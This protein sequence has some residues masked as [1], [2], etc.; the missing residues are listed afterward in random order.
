MELFST[1]S[2]VQRITK[3]RLALVTIQIYLQCMYIRQISLSKLFRILSN[4]GAFSERP[5]LHN[6][7]K[8]V[9]ILLE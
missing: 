3:K 4:Q 7:V 9:G 8:F 1:E 2:L 6:L 5:S